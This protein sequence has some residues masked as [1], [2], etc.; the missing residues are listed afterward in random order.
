MADWYEKWRGFGSLLLDVVS[1]EWKATEKQEEDFYRLR[2]W[3]ILNRTEFLHIWHSYNNS[4][5]KMAHEHT[6]SSSSL[7]HKVFFD[8]Y[9]DPFSYFYKPLSIDQLEHSLRYQDNDMA[10]VML[11]L[12]ERLDECIMWLEKEQ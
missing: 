9:D 11:S 2:T 8:N 7:D 12:K 1:H 10:V 5:R 4:R 3:F 6:G